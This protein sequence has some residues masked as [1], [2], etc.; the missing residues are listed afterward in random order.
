[1]PDIKLNSPEAGEIRDRILGEARYIHRPRGT[2]ALLGCRCGIKA[3][4][5][6]DPESEVPF[7]VLKTLSCPGCGDDDGWRVMWT[8]SAG[9]FNATVMLP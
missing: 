5:E 2:E 6:Y 4:F 9:I 7:D 1:M 3:W 8:H